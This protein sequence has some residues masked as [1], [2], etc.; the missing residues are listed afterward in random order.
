VCVKNLIETVFKAFI[1]SED[2]D[3]VCAFSCD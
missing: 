3:D 1:V 2:D